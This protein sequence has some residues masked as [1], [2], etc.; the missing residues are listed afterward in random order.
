ME[1]MRLL[2]ATPAAVVM[3]RKDVVSIRAD[4]SS[5]AFGILPGHC[6]FMTALAVSVLSFRDQK[7]HTSHVAVRGG[8]LNVRDGSLVE[9]AT[10]EAVVD[11]DLLRLHDSVL[12]RM[13]RDAD[14]EAEAR[15]HTLGLQLR[16]MRQLDRYLRGERPS[17][18][19]FGQAGAGVGHAQ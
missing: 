18:L 14:R 9:V 13:A 3:D 17:G 12:S 10:R 15:T 4:D 6:E 5:G 7:G 8:V 2:I 16:V 11:D 1:T 19:P